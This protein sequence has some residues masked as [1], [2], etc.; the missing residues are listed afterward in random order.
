MATEQRCRVGMSR[1]Q[2]CCWIAMLQE[3]RGE[4]PLGA[5]ATGRYS[6]HL[7]GEV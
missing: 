1:F 7:L 5:Q 6:L 3:Q 2:D 4:S